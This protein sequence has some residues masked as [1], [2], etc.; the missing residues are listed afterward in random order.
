MTGQNYPCSH[1]STP[2]RQ[3][4][5]PREVKSKRYRIVT[6]AYVCDTCGERLVMQSRRLYAEQAAK[7]TNDR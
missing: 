4:K 2:M 6:Y 1:C 5:R 7:V 3:V